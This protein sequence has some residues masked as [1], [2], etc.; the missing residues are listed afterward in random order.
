M[1]RFGGRGVPRQ[2]IRLV[3]IKTGKLCLVWLAT[4]A[5]AFSL[6]LGSDASQPSRNDSQVRF[7][8]F[9]DVRET[10][11][12]YVESGMAGTAVSDAA[13]WDL[14][15]REQDREVRSRIDR[16]IEDSISNLIL[17]G[18][19]FTKLPRFVNSD[20]AMPGTSDNLSPAALARVR[21]LVAATETS[22]RNER[23]EFVNDFLMRK[24]ITGELKEQFLAGI[25]ARYVR[26]QREFQKKLE[27]ARESGDKSEILAARGTLYAQRGL[28]VDTSLLPNFAIEDT[29]RVMLA[30]GVLKAGSIKNIA[31]V[32][33]GL[34]FTD[35]RDGYDFYPLQTIQPFAVME[36]VERL[37]LGKREE[38]R[39][40]TLDLNSA[41]NSHVANLA[42]AGKQGRAYRVQL[43]RDTAALW[44]AQAVN[45]WERFGE[46][47]GT[48][49]KPLAVPEQLPSVKLKAVA[50]TADRATRIIAVD[51]NI[52]AQTADFAEGEGFDLVVATNILVYYDQFQQAL[53]MAN[54]ARMMNPGGIFVSNTALPSAHDDRLKYLGGR[55]V[56][57]AQDGSYGDDVVVYQRK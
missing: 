40:V 52:V 35:K 41:V 57:Y 9:E 37:G 45:Y 21:Q 36:T 23:V 13:D 54:I 12:L 25:L 26:E 30:K 42:A 50:I 4:L 27:T 49:A 14:W 51:L 38:L 3:L 43:P 18:T 1:T 11:A 47:I 39:V 10:L 15:I 7:L 28:S 46:V 31:V 2:R 6:I 22:K 48:P 8:A 44:A 20:E 32:G 34:D 29:L 24:R 33:P 53:A 5:T 19:S 55:N 56:A 16:G 17:Y